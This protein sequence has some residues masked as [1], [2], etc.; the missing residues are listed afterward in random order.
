MAFR[1]NDAVVTTSTIATV[2]ANGSA[3]TYAAT[4]PTAFVFAEGP[5]GDDAFIGFGSD[6]V[7]LT[8]RALFDGDNDGYISAGANGII[9]IDRT[10]AENAGEDNVV[11]AS[12]LPTSNPFE[13]RI[14]GSKGG[15][16]A[17]ADG[18]TRKN[19]WAQFGQENVLEGTIGNDT[20]SA[21]GGPRVILHDNGLG[22][23]LGG[24]TISG[25]GADDLLVTTRQLYDGNDDGTIGFGRNRVLDTSGTGGPNASDPSDGL[26]GQ[27]KFVDSTIRSV[28]YLGSQ[29]INGVTYYYYG[30]S[31]STFVPGGDLA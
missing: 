12:E 21:A 10:S 1:N 7:I 22:L 5:T 24:D 13:L 17:Y 11:I 8:T 26:G 28:E 25:F 2:N 3:D 4:G 30:T 23:N 14:L 29:E 19:L 6:D 18:A 16:F 31:G 15:Q 9:D 27:L 20:I